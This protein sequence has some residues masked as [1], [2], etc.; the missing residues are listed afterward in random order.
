MNILEQVSVVHAACKQTGVC[1]PYS[2]K[3]CWAEL[4]CTDIFAVY[5]T[6]R[7]AEKSVGFAEC[8]QQGKVSALSQRRLSL[9]FNTSR[10]RDEASDLIQQRNK[11]ICAEKEEDG[12]DS[13][14]GIM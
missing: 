11:R 12:I 3:K 13:K 10:L 8:I 4:P 6:L 2:Y 5:L 7:A 14:Q 1:V 9:Q